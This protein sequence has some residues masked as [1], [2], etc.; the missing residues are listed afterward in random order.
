MSKLLK[1]ATQTFRLVLMKTQ[2]K[3]TIS[4]YLRRCCGWS[5]QRRCVR[6]WGEGF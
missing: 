6:E 2:R 5:N 1:G 3:Q 4:I